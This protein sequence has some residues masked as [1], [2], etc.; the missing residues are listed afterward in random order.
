ML[1]LISEGLRAQRIALDANPAAYNRIVRSDELLADV[2]F[3]AQ[4]RG[5]FLW[6]DSELRR[7]V[8]CLNKPNKS[9]VKVNANTG[10]VRSIF[11]VDQ[12]PAAA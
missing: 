9:Y 11:Q 10:K 4:M 5:C 7:A 2:H 1:D 6:A 3:E 12:G 8:I